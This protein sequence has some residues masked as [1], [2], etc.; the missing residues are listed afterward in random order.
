[1]SQY[2]DGMKKCGPKRS[3]SLHAGCG[4]IKPVSEFYKNRRSGDGYQY[5]CKKCKNSINHNYFQQPRQ[6]E[7]N[8]Q[9]SAEY[10]KILRRKMYDN[11]PDDK[12]YCEIC[13]EDKRLVIDHDHET[14]TFRGW[15]CRQCNSGIGM[16]NDDP[17]IIEKALIYIN[18]SL[19]G[20]MLMP[21]LVK[22]H[23]ML[24]LAKINKEA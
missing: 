1:M 2:N 7:K 15:L 16:M 13:G 22:R 20:D 12:G 3:G 4:E 9:R 5:L 14:G 11:L 8:R 21:K 19:Q 24:R 23:G 6:V 18:L 10:Y 17:S